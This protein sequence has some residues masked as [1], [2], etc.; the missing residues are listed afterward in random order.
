MS[1]LLDPRILKLVSDIN[2]PYT[3]CYCEENIYLA[4]Q[5]LVA[6]ASPNLQGVYAVFIS[7][8]TKTAS[9]PHQYGRPVLIFRLTSPVNCVG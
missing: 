8:A 1:V 2:T 4:C 7:N 5:A 6:L 9:N 3:S